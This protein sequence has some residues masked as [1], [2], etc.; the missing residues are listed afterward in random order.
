MTTPT[1]LLEYLT[2]K[3]QAMTLGR[4]ADDFKRPRSE[5]EAILDQLRRQQLVRVPRPGEWELVPDPLSVAAEVRIDACGSTE[6]PQRDLPQILQRHE[7][8]VLNE[9]E[10]NMT[11]RKV[12]T[13]CNTQKGPTAYSDDSDVCRLCTRNG[14]KASSKAP[15]APSATNGGGHFSLA[16]ADLRA[17]AAKLV[18][19]AEL[20]D[21]MV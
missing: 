17:R 11:K 2:R 1:E 5:L 4:I 10:G 3:H 18:A 13:S 15:A 16:A 9:I 8:A 6:K 7:T 12:C 14:G 21:Q 20:L 19:A